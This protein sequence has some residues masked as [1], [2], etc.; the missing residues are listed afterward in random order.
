MSTKPKRRRFAPGGRPTR[1]RSREFTPA[2]VYFTPRYVNDDESHFAPKEGRA[3]FGVGPE[4]TPNKSNS[5]LLTIGSRKGLD[6]SHKR[7]DAPSPTAATTRPRVGPPS[8]HGQ[9]DD[10]MN[11]GAPT[12]FVVFLP[13]PF[14]SSRGKKTPTVVSVLSGGR[15]ACRCLNFCI[16]IG[17]IIRQGYHSLLLLFS[18]EP[19][20]VCLVKGGYLQIP[21]PFL[22]LFSITACF[23]PLIQHCCR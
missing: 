22:C 20:E 18:A 4:E 17:C 8:S 2:S 7:S 19:W 6:P 5:G 10:L 11:H 9:S 16:T 12:C 23:A 21:F 14:V 1:R 15:G 3:R 13:L